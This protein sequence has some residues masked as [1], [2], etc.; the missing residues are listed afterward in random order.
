M[1]ELTI[2][3][4]FSAAHRI[5]GYAGDCARLHGHSWVV[6]FVVGRSS[7]DHLG[8]AM[9]FRVLKEA[10]KRVVGR[11]D[12]QDLNSLEE[13]SGAN[14]SAEN[15]ARIAFERMQAELKNEAARV[16][17]V[18]VWESDTSAATYLPE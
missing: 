18:T 9:D 5:I 3:I 2:K 17:R 10:A 1:F 16:V 4:N 12:H 15:L 14:P 7:V 6:E 11:W 13:F 8:M